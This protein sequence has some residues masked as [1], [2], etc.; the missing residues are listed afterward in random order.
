MK[1][2]EN[3]ATRYDY[4]LKDKLI[5][6]YVKVSLS[7]VFSYTTTATLNGVQI[8]ITVGYNTFNKQRWVFIKDDG[9]NILLPQTFLKYG[10]RCELNFNAELNNLSYYVTLKPKSILNITSFV[11]NNDYEHWMEYFDLCFVGF[12]YELIEKLNTNNFL[13]LVGQL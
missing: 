6:K 8:Y 1:R 3:M 11:E 4:E 9:N 13:Y 10:R 2:I 12:E 5:T 7:D